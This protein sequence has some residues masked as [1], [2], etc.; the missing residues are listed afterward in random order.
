MPAFFLSL[1][2]G[3][4]VTLAG[5]EGVRV[6]RLA[7]A[8]AGKGRIMA[9]VLL[10][11]VCTSALAAWLGASIAPLLSHR[12]LHGFAALALVIA[13]LQVAVLRAP[14]APREPTRSIGATF[15]ALL[16]AQFSD[17]TRFAILALATLSA[18]DWITGAG[19]AIGSAAA[20][21]LVTR[22]DR[23]WERGAP[24][25]ALRLGASAVLLVAGAT[26]GFS[27]SQPAL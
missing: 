19:G 5:R 9:A 12:Y 27:A 22:M 17:A 7:G 8:S 6:A 21:L 14:P 20:L 11:S 24:L 4:A 18:R 26:I 2:V 3:L 15:L 1:I 25:H 13:A 10:A 16:V 23:A